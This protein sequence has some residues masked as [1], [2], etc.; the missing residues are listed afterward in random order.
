[1][2]SHGS[3]PLV[4]MT[5]MSRN[6][7]PRRGSRFIVRAD[8]VRVPV[9]LPFAEMCMYVYL[10]SNVYDPHSFILGLLFGPWSFEKCNQ[11]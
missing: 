3:L 10:R 7:H 8:A 6:M 1:M 5:G 4:F 2:F 11:I 9:F